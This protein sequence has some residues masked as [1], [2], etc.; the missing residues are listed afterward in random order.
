MNIWEPNASG[1]GASGRMRK[2]GGGGG[3][4]DY[5]GGVEGETDGGTG[6]CDCRAIGGECLA[7]YD[8]GG[9]AV[10]SED[11]RVEC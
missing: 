2:K 11:L 6:D 9:G 5:A 8:V 7:V 1:G 10:G 4:Y 3:A